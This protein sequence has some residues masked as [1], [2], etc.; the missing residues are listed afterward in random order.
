VPPQTQLRPADPALPVLQAGSANCS[1]GCLTKQGKPKQANVK[2]ISHMCSDCCAVATQH[3]IDQNL[4]RDACK[5]HRQH[6]V[7]PY[8]GNM[9]APVEAVPAQ[10]L[11][12]SASTAA[13]ALPGPSQPGPRHSQV[14]PSQRKSNGRSLAQPIGPAWASSHDQADNAAKE[15]QS[16]KTKNERLVMQ[17]KRTVELIIYHTV[18]LAHL[19]ISYDHC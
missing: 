11:I 6:F 15:I 7:R 18:R 17:M 3:A 13:S 1:T 4:E 16:L 8:L 5:T 14:G 9:P 12:Q 19:T 2:C 10:E